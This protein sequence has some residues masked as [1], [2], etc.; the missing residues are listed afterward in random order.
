MRPYHEHSQLAL[1]YKYLG[2]FE[3]NE[4][5]RKI[6]AQIKYQKNR[7]LIPF[8]QKSLLRHAPKIAADLL[9]PAPL[10][11][12]RRQER[13][14]N[15]AEEFFRTYAAYYHIPLRADIVYRGKNTQKLAALSPA[16]RERETADIFQVWANKEAELKNKKILLI[17][18]IITTGNTLKKL[19][20]T[21]A[22]CAPASIEIISVFRPAGQANML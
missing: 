16:E 7:E 2:L 1:G 18:D 17:D 6:L 8:I 15:Q 10:N 13:G 19:A 5:A 4:T 14:F 12:L 3:Y 22:R 21:I 11:P 20:E 9:I